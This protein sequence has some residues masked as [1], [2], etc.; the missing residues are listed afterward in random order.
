MNEALGSGHSFGGTLGKGV[1]ASIDRQSLTAS[2][3]DC[4]GQIIRLCRQ[5]YRQQE[6]DGKNQY[7]AS[8]GRGG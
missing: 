1:N 3:V 5:G 2:G 6:D 4:C 7:S 8:Q